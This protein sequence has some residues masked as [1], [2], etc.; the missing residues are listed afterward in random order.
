MA[1]TSRD[2]VLSP[3]SKRGDANAFGMMI[4]LGRTSNNDLVVRN[5]N[6]SKV[7]AYFRRLGG[8]WL[9]NDGGSTNGTF[10]Q[11]TRLTPRKDRIDLSS[12]DEV[13]FAKVKTIFFSPEAFFDYLAELSE[14]GDA[15]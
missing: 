6:V 13:L 3:V 10:H 12:G 2:L 15:G 14:T 9:V 8:E 11:G 1:G 5:L 4:T 7:H